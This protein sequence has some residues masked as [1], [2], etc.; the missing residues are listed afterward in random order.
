MLPSDAAE[1]RVQ[2]LPQLQSAVESDC[3]EVK[4]SHRLKSNKIRNTESPA[5]EGLVVVPAIQIHKMAQTMKEIRIQSYSQFAERPRD[6]GYPGN[7]GTTAFPA[8]SSPDKYLGARTAEILQ[9][10]FDRFS[11][12]M[13]STGCRHGATAR[14][15]LDKI[16]QLSRC[17]S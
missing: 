8:L 6:A 9:P 14:P 11:L 16:D 2:P 1:H 7:T 17:S 13:A 15:D 12:S 3:D 4:S 5:S 10:S